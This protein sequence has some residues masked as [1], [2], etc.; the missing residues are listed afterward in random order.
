MKYRALAVVLIAATGL[1]AL[2]CAGQAPVAP[3]IDPL[4][5]PADTGGDDVNE[6]ML[7]RNGKVKVV[8]WD[9]ENAVREVTVF[10]TGEVLDKPLGI[11]DGTAKTRPQLSV[12]AYDGNDVNYAPL[13]GQTPLAY[14]D[15]YVI[16]PDDELDVAVWR[17]DELS[18]SVR[19]RPDGKVTLPLINDVNAAGLTRAQFQSKLIEMFSAYIAEPEV[20][21]TVVA[22]NSYRVFVQ[23]RVQT[24]GAYEIKSKTT[25][26]QAVAMAGGFTDWAETKNILIVR[27]TRAGEKRFNVDY[28]KIVRARSPD[29][30]FVLRPGDTIIVP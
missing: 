1:L 24:P 4:T 17:N 25:L 22:A 12:V 10:A 6:Y 14:G 29:P 27:R 2:S 28:E 18:K 23:G 19:V 26:V 8:V 15:Q 13:K 21:V 11:S 30:D 16:G 5:Q 3:T 9:G 7:G 20:T